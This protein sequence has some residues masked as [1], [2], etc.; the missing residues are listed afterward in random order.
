MHSFYRLYGPDTLAPGLPPAKSG[1]APK[2]RTIGLHI[3]VHTLKWNW[4][5]TASN[6][7][8][9]V[10]LSVSFQ[11]ANIAVSFIFIFFNHARSFVR[12]CISNFV[13]QV[14]TIAYRPISLYL[15]EGKDCE[16]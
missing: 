10:L 13:M 16:W 8:E 9:T 5:K 6:S 7:C 12:F 3:N 11:C 1:P 4:N 15:D 2:R 14:L